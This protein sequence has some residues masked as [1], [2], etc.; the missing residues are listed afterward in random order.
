M[1]FKICTIGLNFR[2]GKVL[3]R[4]ESTAL[5]DA[6]SVDGI[7][8][9]LKADFSK[10]GVGKGES[11]DFP[12]ISLITCGKHYGILDGKENER[13]RGQLVI[14][15]PGAFHKSARP[16]DSEALI[17]SFASSSPALE[18]LYNRTLTLS[19][20]QE[21][22]FRAIVEDG[23]GLFCYRAPGSEIH[24]MVLKEDADQG[25]LYKMK[26]EL[27][28]FLIELHRCF[29]DEKNTEGKK[30]IQHN[31]DFNRAVRFLSDNIGEN[32]TLSEIAAGTQ[33]SVSKL[34]LLFR[35]KSGGGAVNYFIE[36]KIEKA[37]ELI[38]DGQMNFSEIAQS[39]GFK[40]LHY[41]SRL[42]KKTS[43][44]SPSEFKNN[45]KMK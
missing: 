6:M 1:R 43:G 24:G 7:Y 9:V 19:P 38:L 4:Y 37:K 10:I 22:T 5:P 25:T 2:K 15:A 21:K 3:M 36:M 39:L 30:D 13:V 26:K 20:S 28:L 14:I 23:L 35:E 45:M 34:K 31:T 40:S 44:L 42:F 11:H 17:I 12:E 16:S 18:K 32:L 8:T 33:M 29:A 27:E 41:F